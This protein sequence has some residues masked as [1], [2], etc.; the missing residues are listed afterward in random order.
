MKLFRVLSMVTAL[1]AAAGAAHA[2]SPTPPQSVNPLPYPLER[3]SECPAPGWHIKAWHDGVVIWQQ[4][5][6]MCAS[7]QQTDC[8]QAAGCGLGRL[9]GDVVQPNA[10]ACAKACACCEMCKA[11]KQTAQVQTMPL[12]PE[13][14]R[15]IAGLHGIAPQP[16]PLM[17]PAQAVTQ[18]TQP[19]V[20][21]P[22]I[23]PTQGVVQIMPVPGVRVISVVQV[24]HHVQPVHFVTP[25]LEAHCEHMHHRGDMVI[26]EGSV[27]LVCKKHA[28][29]IRIEA[30]RVIVN[31]RDGSYTVESGAPISTSFGIQRTGA[32]MPPT[33]APVPRSSEPAPRTTPCPADREQIFQF[34]PG[35]FR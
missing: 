8:A 4:L 1:L 25:E 26:L 16:A 30:Q 15:R 33:V 21:L 5:R 27:L 3:T 34:L 32:V 22:P 6:A 35:F 20:C 19:P 12:T 31:M 7:Q 23:A 9:A 14:L 18:L 29:P 24:A 2:Q 11:K 28:M 10:C 17:M 13:M